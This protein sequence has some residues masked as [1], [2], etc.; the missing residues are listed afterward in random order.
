[1]SL[2]PLRVDFPVMFITAQCRWQAEIMFFFFFSSPRCCKRRSQYLFLITNY[3]RRREEE[4]ERIVCRKRLEVRLVNARHRCSKG[5][6]LTEWSTEAQQG[7]SRCTDTSQEGEPRSTT[8]KDNPPLHCSPV[9]AVS[10]IC[11]HGFLSVE[12]NYIKKK[13][14]RVLSSHLA[15]EPLPRLGVLQPARWGTNENWI[16]RLG[17]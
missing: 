9:I 15:R 13:I 3:L 4:D 6:Y 16:T 1:M 2:K 11:P 17:D 8:N 14:P 7:H 10:L 5:S 12:K